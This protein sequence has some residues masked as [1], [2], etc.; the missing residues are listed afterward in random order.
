MKLKKFRVT[1]FRSV[2]D[3]GWVELDLVNALLGENES[4]KTNLLLPLWK[5]NPAADGEIDLL[6]D[7]PRGEY[8]ENTRITR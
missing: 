6:C 8:S 2:Q 7:A 4:G 3:S 5:L 1:K